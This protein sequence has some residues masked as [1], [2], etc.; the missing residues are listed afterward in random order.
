MN[1]SRLSPSQDQKQAQISGS[2]CLLSDAFGVFFEF[3]VHTESDEFE[4]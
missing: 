4:M 3:C 2:W 1:F